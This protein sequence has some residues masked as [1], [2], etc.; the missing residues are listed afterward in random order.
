MEAQTIPT[1]GK[2]DL[3][4]CLKN[5]NLHIILN[6]NNMQKIKSNLINL[7]MNGKSEREYIR[8]TSWKIF[9][10]TL[11]IIDNNSSL[12]IWLEETLSKR[13]LIKKQLQNCAINKLKGDPLGGA[14]NSNDKNS[15]D[16]FFD[17]SETQNFIK[18]DVNRT[19][20]GQKLF[21]EPFIH[22]MQKD[23]LLIYFKNNENTSYKQGMTDI[24]STLIYALYPFYFKNPFQINSNNDFNNWINEPEKYSKE[25]YH[26]LHDENSFLYDIYYLFENIMNKAGL[27][28]Y[29]DDV[30]INKNSNYKP[31]LLKKCENI[32]L[33]KLRLQDRKLYLHFLNEKLDYFMILQRYL[34]CLFNR[35]FDI[36][37]CII[38]WDSILANESFHPSGELEYVDYIV[39]SMI[40]IIRDDLIKLDSENMLH[41]LM[42]YP[43]IKS[44]RSFLDSVDKVRQ[45]L[46][47]MIEIEERKKQKEVNKQKQI[48]D[49]NKKNQEL[50][51]QQQDINNNLEINKN[52]ILISSPIPNNNF[53]QNF[54][55]NNNTNFMFMQ[56]N[57]PNLNMISNNNNTFNGFEIIDKKEL[58]PME[59]LKSTYFTSNKSCVDALKQLKDI[60]NIY[61]NKISVNDKN[62]IDTLINE[63]SKK[64]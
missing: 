7:A 17:E 44:I 37:D 36:D 47:E 55:F 18:N 11:P 28:K 34:K 61:K 5:F 32:I 6:I 46:C 41:M 51:K 31:F 49:M 16:K 4:L 10:N 35:E 63:L 27:I 33:S 56:Y 54:M 19:K 3:E 12:K 8:S 40:L 14:G 25:I 13:K 60:I 59:K 62:R 42:H 21:K 26:F 2:N 9:L 30:S 15:W 48:D 38:L 23:I 1:Y 22:K 52:K 57:S 20:Q 24:L 58:T 53:T 39:I 64:L 50:L 45:N 43:K 29:Y